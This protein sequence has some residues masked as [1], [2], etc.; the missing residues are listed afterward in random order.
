[1]LFPIIE[2]LPALGGKPL[3]ADKVRESLCGPR[4]FPSTYRLIGEPALT[5][6]T[7]SFVALGG[8]LVTVTFT[9]PIATEFG[10]SVKTHHLLSPL[11]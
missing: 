10:V 4:S 8:G 7:L 9:V 11:V 2:T 1:M 5:T 6:D 3:T